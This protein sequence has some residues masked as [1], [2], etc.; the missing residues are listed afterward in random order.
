MRSIEEGIVTAS[1]VPPPRLVDSCTVPTIS[2]IV[3]VVCTEGMIVVVCHA[4]SCSCCPLSLTDVETVVVFWAIHSELLVRPVDM[5]TTCGLHVD[6]GP[7][8]RNS[9][10]VQLI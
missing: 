3:T 2:I 8:T 4:I 7:S 6:T 1:I 5:S 9:W 10:Y